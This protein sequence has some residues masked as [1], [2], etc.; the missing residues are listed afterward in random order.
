MST[1]SRE[2]LSGRYSHIRIRSWIGTQVIWC[3]AFCQGHVAAVRLHPMAS[4]S[5]LGLLNVRGMMGWLNQKDSPRKMHCCA[6]ECRRSNIL[7]FLSG[8]TSR[9]WLELFARPGHIG[10]WR[11]RSGGTHMFV[12]S[13][14]RHTFLVVWFIA[15][16]ILAGASA[17]VGPASYGFRGRAGLVT[18][19]Q[20]YKNL[21]YVMSYDDRFTCKFPPESAIEAGAAASSCNFCFPPRSAFK[22]GIPNFRCLCF[23]IIQMYTFGLSLVHIVAFS[24]GLDVSTCQFNCAS[25]ARRCRWHSAMLLC[26]S[27]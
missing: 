4:T 11:I 17:A 3:S 12:H 9:T 23:G 22:R 10:R 2:L 26:C 18:R 14:S 15:C 27:V 24:L 8:M 6:C 13:R 21:R 7:R 25:V 16:L 19:T 5:V 20:R 1:D